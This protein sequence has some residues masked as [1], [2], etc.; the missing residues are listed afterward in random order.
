MKKLFTLIIICTGLF[1]EAQ[2]YLER[3]I[4]SFGAKGDGKTND[5]A[6]FQK[7]ADFF[8]QRKGHGKLTISKGNY[9]VGKQEFTKGKNGKRAYEGADLMNFISVSN[10]DIT[11]TSTSKI[12]Y[13]GKLKFGAFNPTTGKAHTASGKNFTK[14]DWSAMLGNC[15]MI[16]DSKDVTVSNLELDGN[17]LN[18]ERGGIYGDVGI[19][20]THVGINITNS[21]HITVEDVNVHHFGL[22]GIYVSNIETA[23]NDDIKISNS[24]FEYNSR[25]GLSWVGGNDLKVKNSKF[26]HTGQAGFVS[27][28]GAGIDIEAEV[29][30]VKNGKFIDCE[31][32]NNKGPGVGADS[33]PSSNCEFIN[34]TFVGVDTWALWIRKPGFK[35]EDCKIYGAF[36]HGYDA[37]NDA[38]ATKFNNCI[39][40]DKPYNGKPVFGAY[41]VESNDASRLSFINCNF[42]TR[43]KKLVWTVHT[44]L[45]T[46][47]ESY[48]FDN[49]TFTMYNNNIAKGD[50][51][52]NMA[53]IRYKDC[54]FEFRDRVA[55]QNGYFINN[56]KYKTNIDDGGNR[57]VYAQ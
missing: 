24:A 48:L 39:F 51:I 16:T 1:A 22:D 30:P 57:I 38:E 52:A 36:V 25:Q 11:G 45:N 55:K 28:P 27:A 54:R 9:I 53:G 18:I 4:K 6:A 42:I 37:K 46:P 43:E 2:D 20:L 3:D 34:C 19:Q 14:R 21:R 8:N 50:F 56:L 40:E 31:V 13:G 10:F 47:D 7:A 33:G 49:C 12:T 15:I 17:N 26:N 44:E 5:H 32:M 41:L 35:F 29:G 23:E